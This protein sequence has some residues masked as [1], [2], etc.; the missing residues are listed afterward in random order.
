MFQANISSK[1]LEE[2]PIR[3]FEGDIVV[4]DDVNKV[5]PAVEYLSKSSILGFDT[6]T[7]P[8]FVKGKKHK[9]ALMQLST[10]ERAYLFRVGT[11]GIP[12]VLSDLLED[13]SILKIGAAVKEDLKAL[14]R[15][16]PFTPV[17]F[18]DLQAIVKQYG[19][20]DMSVR[21]LA[22]IVLGMRI[23]KSQ[24]LSNWENTTLTEAQQRYAATDAWVCREIYLKLLQNTP[25]KS[26]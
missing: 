21:K 9:V 19:I 7:R 2:L 5:K 16:T 17:G 8:S 26:I 1:E 11:I 23:S 18:I 13:G 20:L 10:N 14:N 6:E 25:H 4:V 15:N 12:N 3:F 22:A 24:Q